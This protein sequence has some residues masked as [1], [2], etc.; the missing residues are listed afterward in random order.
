MMGRGWVCLGLLAFAAG[1]SSADDPFGAEPDFKSIE[2]RLEKPTGTFTQGKEA[3]LFEQYASRR[4]SS[5]DIDVTG[6][7][8][9][10]A[11]ASSSSSIRSQ[12]LEL[13]DA[14]LSGSSRVS[15]RD[16]QRGNANGTCFC[17]SGGTFSYDFSGAQQI[18]RGGPID[19][20]LKVRFQGCASHDTTVDGRE[21]VKLKSPGH[22][23][24]DDLSMIF[25]LDVE[26]SRGAD[27]H[28]I[29][30]DLLYKNGSYWL[31]L[32]VDDGTIVIGASGYDGSTKSGTITVRDRSTTWTCT[33]T[34]G[35]GS[36]TNA[37]GATRTLGE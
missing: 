33:L 19:V 29:D 16:L 14:G 24:A 22:A 25:T 36:C 11:A 8:S 3:I 1:C 18:R 15:C 21:F 35:K 28:A 12:A 20:T 2:E 4:G 9:N 26:M 34:G 31:S 17:P 23:T 30:L 37:E 10:A 7:D 6:S 32:Q 13:L 5:N 27:K